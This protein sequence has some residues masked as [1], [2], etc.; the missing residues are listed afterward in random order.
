MASYKKNLEDLKARYQDGIVSPLIGTGFSLNAYSKMPLWDDLLLDMAKEQNSPSMSEAELRTIIKSDPVKVVSHYLESHTRVQLDHYIQQR[1]PY[2]DETLRLWFSPKVGTKPVEGITLADSDLHLHY[3]LLKGCWHDI[4]TT[5]YDNLL[6]V[7]SAR[8]GYQDVVTTK[9]QDFLGTVRDRHIFKL[10]GDI[11]NPLSDKDFDHSF[12]GQQGMRYV[13]SADDYND[14]HSK[15]SAFHFSISNNLLGGAFCLIGFSGDDPNF[16]RWRDWLKS[17]IDNTVANQANEKSTN[18]AIYLIDVSETEKSGDE[19]LYRSSYH[20]RD[21]FLNDPDVRNALKLS[22]DETS[23]KELLTH[24]LDYLYDTDKKQQEIFLRPKDYQELWKKS[25]TWGQAK[26][27][28]NYDVLKDIFLKKQDNR[29]VEYTYW[30][31][32]LIDR[33]YTKEEYTSQDVDYILCALQDTMYVPGQYK[34]MDDRIGKAQLTSKQ[35]ALYNQMNNREETLFF[36]TDRIEA[37]DDATMYEKVLRCLFLFE[38]DT[39]VELLTQWQP[40]GLYVVKKAVFMYLLGQ[41]ANI[42]AVEDERHAQSD[43]ESFWITNILNGLVL[44]QPLKYDTTGYES[45]GLRSLYEV[46]NRFMD[47]CL[48]EKY[49][50]EPYGTTKDKIFWIGKSDVEYRRAFRFIQ[51]LIEMPQ[52]PQLGIVSF[53]NAGKWYQVFKHLFERVPYAALFYSALCNEKKVLTRIGQDYAYSQRLYTEHVTEDL[54]RRMLSALLQEHITPQIAEGIFYICAQL[55]VSVKP[56][57]WQDLYYQIWRKY[58]CSNLTVL[59]TPNG[60]SDFIHQGAKYLTDKDIVCCILRD[61]L[62]RTHE[63]NEIPFAIDMFYYLRKIE[64]YSNEVEENFN[65]FIDNIQDPKEFVVITN[66]HYYLSDSQAKRISQKILQMIKDVQL[67]AI[68]FRPLCYYAKYDESI[69]AEVKRCIIRSPYLWDNGIRAEYA[70]SSEP[71]QLSHF[72]NILTWEHDELIAIYEQL[73]QKFNQLVESNFYKRNEGFFIISKFDELLYEMF[74]FLESNKKVLSSISDYKQVKG[75]LKKELNNIR[76]FKKIE[77]AL[78]SDDKGTYAWGLRE[79]LKKYRLGDRIKAEDLLILTLD[80][81]ILQNTLSFRST[82][83]FISYILKNYYDAKT[84]SKNVRQKY[85]QLLEIY[86]ESILLSLDQEI[87]VTTKYFTDIATYM[88]SLGIHSQAITK[89][90]KFKESKRYNTFL[91]TGEE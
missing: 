45:K 77:F 26:A 38:I 34:G 40:S 15:H 16:I 75:R 79:M 30:Q 58:V 23:P 50:V 35:Q 3:Q 60:I 9:A 36:P 46:S 33:I 37:V 88:K 73:R 81:T 89:W 25:L 91:E 84:L 10:H 86:D 18:T 71:I 39:A 41:Q 28:V 20:I 90:I 27:T 31:E 14:Y 8:K 54:L 42:H 5:N 24:F 57:L 19:I 44:Q 48:N 76:G 56:E 78:A 85:L 83:D 62:S 17:I 69:L 53:I 7:A 68:T 11:W 59:E 6:E 43:Q 12:D 1:I 64:I 65:S 21:I 87:P 61:T 2:I 66:I 22:A 70:T 49:P 74:D 72:K 80:K 82:L 52:L 13:I 51:F 67:P 47:A 32:Q 63:K 29:I 55:F 4:Y